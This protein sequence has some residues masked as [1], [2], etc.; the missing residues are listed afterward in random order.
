[1]RNSMKTLYFI[2]S[3]IRRTAMNSIWQ[4]KNLRRDI[5]GSINSIL[6]GSGDWNNLKAL[7]RNR[8]KALSYS[9][10]MNRVI[11]NSIL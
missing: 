6:H 4:P 1:M 7:M 3:I 2:S 11:D 5:G 10:I 9:S 8:K